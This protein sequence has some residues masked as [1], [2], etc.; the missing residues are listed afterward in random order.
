MSATLA[1]VVVRLCTRTLS[2]ST[3]ICAFM[4]QYHSLPFFVWC[5]SPSRLCSAFL[6]DDGDPGF[7]AVVIAVDL[8]L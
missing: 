5:M 6:V 7:G 2:A 3:P 1:A 4:P 8:Q